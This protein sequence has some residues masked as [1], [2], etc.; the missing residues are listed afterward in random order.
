MKIKNCKLKIAKGI[1][2]ILLPIILVA[3]GYF[4]MKL[5]FFR[6]AMNETKEAVAI[7]SNEKTTGKILGEDRDSFA[8]QAFTSENFHASQITFGGD[9]I[10]MSAGDQSVVPEILDM[11]SELLT[12]RT[13]QQV[14]FLLSWRTNK[15]CA[16]SI[17]YAK[18]GQTEE[19]I[20]S[21]DSYGFFHSVEIAPLNYSTSYSYTV[22]VRDKWG[23]EIKSDK[24][25][26]YTGVQNV[27][28]FDII[29]AAFKDMFGW[30]NK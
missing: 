12:T 27:S 22:T 15:L 8:S 6:A 5:L 11:R 10:T 19:K 20:V 23:N 9:A 7:I 18:E 3:L 24:L 30:M 16:S 4:S 21:E 13:D 14:K 26:F 17:A 2:Y 25:A 29:A 1:K 28:I